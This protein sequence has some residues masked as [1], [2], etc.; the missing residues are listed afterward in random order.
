VSPENEL[1][2]AEP[3]SGLASS[4]P[5]IRSL[6]PAPPVPERTGAD[7]WI[8]RPMDVAKQF[9]VSTETVAHW[10]DR[11]LI[12]VRKTAGGHRRYRPSD[13]RAFLA[14]QGETVHIADRGSGPRPERRGD[15]ANPQRLHQSNR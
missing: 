12:T 7:A 15:H 5:G 3:L 13:L 9:G 8:L 2:T 11:G 6:S 14:K 10:S 4:S 1:R